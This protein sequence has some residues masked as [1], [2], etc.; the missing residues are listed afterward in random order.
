M[1]PSVSGSVAL[2]FDPSSVIVAVP[3]AV[4]L[5]ECAPPT[6]GVWGRCPLW[7]ARRRR[8]SH[9]RGHPRRLNPGED[10]LTASARRPVQRRSAR[11]GS[12]RCPPPARRG[13]F[14]RPRPP[15]FD[16]GS[17]FGPPPPRGGCPPPL[18]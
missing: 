12:E 3:L 8:R 6:R 9:A 18:P 13:G 4:L 5:I 10:G 2:R 14:G 11:R 17:R 16:A 7:L 15:G 1:V